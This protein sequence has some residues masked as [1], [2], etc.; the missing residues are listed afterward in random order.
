MTRAPSPIPH[1]P[2]ISQVGSSPAAGGLFAALLPANSYD[3]QPEW[4]RA[5]N[6]ARHR[7]GLSGAVQLPWQLSFGSLMS[8]RSGLPFN[9]A[10]GQD[11]AEGVANV[12]PPGITRNTG[13]GPGQV[14]LDV[15]LGRRVAIHWG[16]R[17][18]DADIGIDS[19]NV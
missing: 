16:D 6:D 5:N 3:L 9:I 1:I 8:I 7:F 12:R 14:S 17:K 19:F 15:H 11:N 18:I 10:A 13:K 2:N 4:G